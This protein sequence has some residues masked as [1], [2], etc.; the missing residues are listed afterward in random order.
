MRGTGKHA[1]GAAQG[2]E[3]GL[4]APRSPW[5]RSSSAPA[6]LWCSSSALPPSTV[7]LWPLTRVP[8]V[9]WWRGRPLPTAVLSAPSGCRHPASSS[10]ALLLGRRQCR[11][12]LWVRVVFVSGPSV[13]GLLRLLLALGAPL[14]GRRGTGPGT[15]ATCLRGSLP[16][17]TRTRGQVLV[18]DHTAAGR[19]EGEL[20]PA[21][22]SGPAAVLAAP[23][24]GLVLAAGISSKALA[25]ASRSSR[26]WEQRRASSPGLLVLV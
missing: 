2:C 8:T 12:L 20:Q 4:G 9:S 18:E 22:K 10:L 21:P 25:V 24:G 16:A 1:A 3:Q 7:E 17:L 23:G 11:T 15:Q 6:P 14:G 19:P 5:G 26:S 13:L